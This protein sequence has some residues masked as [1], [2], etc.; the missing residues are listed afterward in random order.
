MNETLVAALA[1][2]LAPAGRFEIAT[3]V[4]EYF[5]VIQKLIADRPEFAEIAGSGNA[6]RDV[7]D[8][9]RAKVSHRGPA[10]LSRELP[11]RFGARAQDG[12]F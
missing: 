10:D 3:D 7:F 4:E 6:E 11:A 2:A 12:E 1:R 8:E 9:L 5:G